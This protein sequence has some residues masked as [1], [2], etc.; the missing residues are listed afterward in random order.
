MTLIENNVI[1]HKPVIEN[2]ILLSKFVCVLPK[3]NIIYFI[4]I[5]DGKLVD[6]S[7]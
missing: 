4:L 7:T 6:W 1:I 3:I 5:N 2:N